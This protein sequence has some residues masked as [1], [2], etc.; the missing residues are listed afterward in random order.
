LPFDDDYRP[1]PAF[2]AV[3]SAMDA[4]RAM[5]QPV[6]SKMPGEIDP[7]SLYKPFMV[8]GSPVKPQ[9]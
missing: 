5:V 1:A 7:G 8:P 6:V 4:S 9:R 3:R 2:E